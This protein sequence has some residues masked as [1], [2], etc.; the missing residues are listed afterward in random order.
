MSLKSVVKASDRRSLAERIF[1]VLF[2]PSVLL[3]YVIYKYPAW[4]LPEGGDP[5]VFHVLG[6]NPRFW[7]ATFYT[8]IVCGTCVWVLTPYAN[9]YQRSKKKGPLSQYQ[10][11]KFTSILLA[12]PVAFYLVPYVLPAL[13]QTGGFFNDPVRVAEKAAHIYVYPAFLSWGGAIYMF[14]VIPLAVWFF[15]KRYG[16]WYCSCGNLAEAVG[17]L[18]WGAK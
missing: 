5:G 14:A 1:L 9:R 6:K 2:Y 17:V 12:P 16:S 11:A 10:R 7:Y 8:A 18:P 4:L 15:G 13:W 3:F